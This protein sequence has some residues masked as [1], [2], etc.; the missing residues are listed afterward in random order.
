MVL[1][2]SFVALF[3]GILLIGLPFV[4]AY[5]LLCESIFLNTDA[6]DSNLLEQCGNALLTPVQ[7]IFVGKKAYST[8]DSEVPYRLENKFDYIDLWQLKTIASTALLAPSIAWGST[9]KGLAYLSNDT[10]SRHKKIS[11]SL[12][13]NKILPNL[14]AYISAGIHVNEK[15]KEAPWAC[16]HCYPRS[17]KDI[18]NLQGDKEAL[19]EI[20]ALLEKENIPYWADCG[21]CL[22]VYRHQG[23]IPWDNDIDIAILE[24]DFDNVRRALSSLDPK[25]FAVLD[26]SSRDKPK[27][28]LKVYVKG[29]DILIDIYHYRLNREDKTLAY[30]LSNEDNIF[31]TETWK[32]RE[33]HYK[34][35]VPFDMIFP[36]KRAKFDNIELL[37]P[38]QIEEYLKVRYGENLAPVMLYNAA[39][40]KYE[41]DLSH[42]YWQYME[43]E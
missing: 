19:K 25:K 31:L 14:E 39:T 12:M 41:K 11:Q 5:T 17:P 3:K 10:R 21:T 30:V 9:L 24:P 15:L 33:R 32:K 4:Y 42:P 34:K 36:L 8:G 18:N 13:S 22:G 16:T 37:V 1:S 43:N 29:T 40:D 38:N 35:P 2:H 7:Y 26:W 27:T 28:Y 6:D 23:V 20:T